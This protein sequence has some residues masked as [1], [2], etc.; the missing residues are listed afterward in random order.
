MQQ[1]CRYLLTLLMV[2]PLSLSGIG[3]TLGYI[4]G[5]ED[6]TIEY[7]ALLPDQHY[8]PNLTGYGLAYDTMLKDGRIFNYRLNIEFLKDREYDIEQYNMTHT[9]GFALFK[10]PRLRI[11]LGPRVIMQRTKR[12][13]Y[14][15]DVGLALAPALG[16]NVNLTPYLTLSADIDRHFTT[17]YGHY[18]DAATTT[19][20]TTDTRGTSF[21]L[22]LFF[23]F[24]E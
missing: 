7:D 23:C 3:F 10:N 6:T 14:H 8:T 20:Y 13:R 11:W 16:I 24:R 1:I 17:H 15:D 22:Y 19:D 12:G 9:F 18:E 2:A 4:T 21:R 5:T